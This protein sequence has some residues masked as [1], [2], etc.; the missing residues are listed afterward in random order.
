MVATR[1][2]SAG[3]RYGR[4]I[5]VAA[6]VEKRNHGWMHEVK[7]DCGAVKLVLGKSLYKGDSKSCGCLQIER[8][9]K[10]GKTKTDEYKVWCAMITRCTNQNQDGFKNYGG[11][12][13]AVCDEWGDFDQFLKD[14]GKRPSKNHSLER[15]DND[16]GYSAKNCVWAGRFAQSQNQRLRSDNKTGH[17]GVCFE[18]ATGKYS[19]S[20]QR[21]GKR[22]YLGRYTDLTDAINAR[23]SGENTLN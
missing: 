23:V 11:R 20:I 5:I 8:S 16:L 10:H 4:L 1:K 17:K 3:N 2:A 22:V 19:V 15:V 13:I 21:N 18:K 7:C 14:M 6:Y 9:T 12:G